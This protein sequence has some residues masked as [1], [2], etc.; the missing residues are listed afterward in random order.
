MSNVTIFAGVNGAGKTTLYYNEIE[1]KKDFGLRI[2]IDE[3][4]SSF[5]DWRDRNDQIR[6]S[7]LA[8]IMRNN[9]IRK[10][11][12]FNQETTL[13]GKSILRLFNELKAKNYHIDLYY[14]G[15]DSIEIAKERVKIR[16]A[17]GGH[18]IEPHIIE[19]RY[20]QSLENLSKILHLC[21]NV[22]VFDNSIDYKR[23]IE[24]KNNK[25]TILQENNLTRIIKPYLTKI[26][27]DY[28]KSKATSKTKKPK[29]WRDKKGRK[30]Q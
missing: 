11:Q 8:I 7:K 2:N 27:L 14:V 22:I 25:Q 13:C 20:Y 30:L 19:H 18:N 28:C 23:I 5:G 3:I 9:Y 15:L 21:D 1:R 29:E 12:S 10:N 24:I 4:V 6:A 26:P 16:V 17:K